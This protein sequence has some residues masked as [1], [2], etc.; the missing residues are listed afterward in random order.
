MIA[1]LVAFNRILSLC[2]T[3]LENG[4]PHPGPD[5]RNRIRWR[6]GVKPIRFPSPSV[7]DLNR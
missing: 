6:H 5:W 3:A 1:S 4:I 7:K 2:V